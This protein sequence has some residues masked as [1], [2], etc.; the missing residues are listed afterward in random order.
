MRK[1]DMKNTSLRNTGMTNTSMRNTG[2][3]NNNRNTIISKTKPIIDINQTEESILAMQE[4]D[5]EFNKIVLQN[6]QRRKKNKD[7]GNG[8]SNAKMLY[9][10]QDD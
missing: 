1:K 7:N 3:I 6:S 4:D 8:K 5:L 2:K 9:M 10:D